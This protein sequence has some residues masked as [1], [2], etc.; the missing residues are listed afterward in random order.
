MTRL[1]R[2]SARGSPLLL[3]AALALLFAPHP[4]RASLG[5]DRASVAADADQFGAA[6]TLV[7]MPRY[8]VETLAGS[9]GT[10]V[11]EYLNRG[12]VV[13]AVSWRGPA[14]PNLAALLGV[15][16]AEYA[17]ALAAR[18]HPGLNRSVA[19]R[20]ASGLVVE[21]GGHLRAFRGRAY[22]AA[23]LPAGLEPAELW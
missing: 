14:A 8:D 17:A 22:L 23:S 10:E 11:R 19:V 6:V 2:A 3:A 4:V 18:A 1:A 21:A 12:G 9:S 5:G 20:T 13:F 15:R 7:S 16:F